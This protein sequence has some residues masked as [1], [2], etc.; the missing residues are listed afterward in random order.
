M[1]NLF[2]KREIV[3]ANVTRRPAP[4][5][6]S[7]PTP[8][9]NLLSSEQPSAEI[10][11]QEV[12]QPESNTPINTIRDCDSVGSMVTPKEVDSYNIN[13]QEPMTP[14]VTQPYTT[15][16]QNNINNPSK[17]RMVSIRLPMQ[18]YDI[19]KDNPSE[20]VRQAITKTYMS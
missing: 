8:Q 12:I 3:Y 11:P 4:V 14:I 5:L 1:F 18:L 2:K 15:T 10:K 16:T 9:L 13:N 6:L 17:S 20:K 7:E 19:V